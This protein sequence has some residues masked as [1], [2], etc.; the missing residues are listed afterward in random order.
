MPVRK[1]RQQTLRDLTTLAM[2][3][4]LDSLDTMLDR[5]MDRLADDSLSDMDESDEVDSDHLDSDD[6]E[7]DELL[8]LAQDLYD[9]ADEAMDNLQS[10]TDLRYHE[11]RRK[12][13]TVPAFSVDDM[14]AMRS[15][16]FRHAMRTTPA[17][18][19]AVLRLI[20]DHPVFFSTS[21]NPPPSVEHQLAMTLERL[22]S[23]G[24]GASLTRISRYYKMSIGCV[25]TST[26]RVVKAIN[27]RGAGYLAWPDKDRREEISEVLAENGFPQ[28]VGFVDGTTIPLHQKPGKDGEV[29]WDRKKDYSIN[30]QIVCDCDRR[31][32]ALYTGWPGSCSD[33]TTY[34]QMELATEPDEHFSP[35]LSLTVRG[36]V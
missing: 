20:E 22:G 6:D 8:D 15:T 23:N 2:V 32:T 28:C 16:D 25:V 29:F 31:I 3:A 17:C 14:L 5:S 18:F 35:G 7:A 27:D 11:E 30:A 21:R 13:R 19:E 26:R 24:N 4:Q 36:I 33:T 1:P 10:A 12:D 9:S 34:E